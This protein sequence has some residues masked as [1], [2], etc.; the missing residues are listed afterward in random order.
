M[1]AAYVQ[2][3][4]QDIVNKNVKDIQEK[5]PPYCKKTLDVI[6]PIVDIVVKQRMELK[7]AF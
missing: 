1:E 5:L 4:L 3:G 2:T 7:Y 6:V